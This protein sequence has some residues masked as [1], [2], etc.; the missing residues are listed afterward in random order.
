MYDEVRLSY[1]E[2]AKDFNILSMGMS[3]DYRLAI[4]CGSNMVRIGSL[5]FGSR[6]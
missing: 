1:P 4:Q 3:G 6:N 5:I 2:A